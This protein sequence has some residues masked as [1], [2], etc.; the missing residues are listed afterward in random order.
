MDDSPKNVDHV[1]GVMDRVA[2]RKPGGNTISRRGM[3]FA[4]LERVLAIAANNL[5]GFEASLAEARRIAR[6]LEKECK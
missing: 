3:M 1:P 4:N 5:D 6:D 2:Q